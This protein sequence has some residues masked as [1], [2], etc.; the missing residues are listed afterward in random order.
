MTLYSFLKCQDIEAEQL[1]STLLDK[2]VL[3]HVIEHIPLYIV[4]MM[5]MI[6]FIGIQ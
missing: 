2:A 4:D 6:N 1:P 3:C 5:F